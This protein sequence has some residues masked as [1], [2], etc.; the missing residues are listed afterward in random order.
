MAENQL[1][2]GSRLER[3]KFMAKLRRMKR[4]IDQEDECSDCFERILV[5]LIKWGTL[6]EKRAD[7]KKSGL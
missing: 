4:D 6:A 5:E 3:Q 1:Q 2:K 7:A